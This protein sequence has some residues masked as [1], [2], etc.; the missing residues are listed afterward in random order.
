LSTH[1]TASSFR[2]VKLA[3]NRK[4]GITFSLILLAFA[5]WPMFS[6]AG[7]KLW[8]LCAAFV[9]LIVTWLK[10]GWLGPLNMAWFRVGLALNAVVNPIIMAMLY[11][12]A[13]VPLGLILRRNGKDLLDLERCPDAVTYWV[14]REPAGPLPG[15]FNK[16]F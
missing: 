14:R 16:Q 6:G 3:S 11:F 7:P 5:L 1:E 9:L 8:F 10:P 2:Q 4:F 12:G 15:T 13:V